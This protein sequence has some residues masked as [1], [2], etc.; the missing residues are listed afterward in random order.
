MAKKNWYA[1]RALQVDGETVAEIRIYEEIGFWGMTATQFMKELDEVAQD[2]VRIVVSINSP[3]GDVFDAFTI[4]NALRRHRLPV[5]ARVDGVAASAA[6]LILMAGD[7]IIMPEN[8]MV[9]IHNAWTVAA[10][11]ADELRSTADMMDKVGD[12]IVAAY[13]AKSGQET[14]KVQEMMDA[15]TW[16][17]ALEAQALG[18]CDIIEEPVKLAASAR[19]FDLLAK[20]KGVPADLLASIDEQEPTEPS[21]G[22]VEA[23]PAADPA[24]GV[25]AKD[26]K[27]D[28]SSNVAVTAPTARA[29]IAQVTA[30]CKEGGFPSLAN[31]IILSGDFATPEQVQARVA[32][33]L[34][35]NGLCIAANLADKAEDFIITGLGVEAV[36]AR[37]FDQVVQRSAGTISNL[38]R[39]TEPEPESRPP[40]ISAVNI[41]HVRAQSRRNR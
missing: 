29:L 36:R 39:P 12:G 17:S 27:N 2:A 37:L 40:A 35:I 38:Q 19:A 41:Y 1:M 15:T 16:L 4:Y 9:M 21:P 22:R 31:A 3:G 5:D 14:D 34:E 8:A 6:S 24:V 11:T 7:R 28:P 26:D 30:A 23:P 20:H 18:F 33:A 13:V 32:D 10:G 25:K